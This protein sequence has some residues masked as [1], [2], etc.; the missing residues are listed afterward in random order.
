MENETPSPLTFGA[1]N[2]RQYFGQLLDRFAAFKKEPLDQ[3]LA[4]ECA[5]YAVFIIEWIAQDKGPTSRK[6]ISK[7][8]QQMFVNCPEL[9]YLQDLANAQRHKSLSFRHAPSLKKAGLHE[10]PF[11]QEFESTFDS[12]CLILTLDDGTE[13][14]YDE[15]LRK[16]VEFWIRY[17][18]EP[19][20]Q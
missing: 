6:E 8:Q 12:S 18:G 17:F 10:G 4:M 16:A 5:N 2:A 3:Q 20:P 1:Q 9:R 13:L 19:A 14:L 11:S 15:V 7:L